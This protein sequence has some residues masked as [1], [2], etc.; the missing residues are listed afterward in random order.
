MAQLLLEGIDV[1]EQKEGAERKHLLRRTW[2]QAPDAPASAIE[3][4]TLEMQN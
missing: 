2:K 4:P 1:E 3:H